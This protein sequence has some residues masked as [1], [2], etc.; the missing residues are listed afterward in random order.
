MKF[1]NQNPLTFNSVNLTNL[2][3]VKFCVYF[4]PVGYYLILH[5]PGQVT[6]D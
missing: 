4:H 1:K 5:L 6:I 2:S 3:Q